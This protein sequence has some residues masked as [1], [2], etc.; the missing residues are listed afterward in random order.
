MLILHYRTLQEDTTLPIDQ[1][2]RTIELDDQEFAGVDLTQPAG[3]A[4]AIRRIMDNKI[5]N[6]APITYGSV[7]Y[8]TDTEQSPHWEISVQIQKAT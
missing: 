5:P 4:A 7:I 8:L 1:R 2:W 3:V 6:V